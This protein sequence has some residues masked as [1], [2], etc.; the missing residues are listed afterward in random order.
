[1]SVVMLLRVKADVAKFE[2]YARENGDTL[3][4]VHPVCSCWTAFR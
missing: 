2:E 3:N 1:M 4:R